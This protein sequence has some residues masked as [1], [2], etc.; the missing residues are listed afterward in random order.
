LVV[1]GEVAFYFVVRDERGDVRDGHAERKY[2]RAPPA[3][4]RRASTRSV[5]NDFEEL[6]YQPVGQASMCDMARKRLR[7]GRPKASPT[8]ESHSLLRSV[9]AYGHFA[10][11]T[12]GHGV[13]HMGMIPAPMHVMVAGL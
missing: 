4:Y 3:G 6:T 7:G 10:A 8:F 1:L 12:A 5:N 13:P 2:V 11:F 9:A